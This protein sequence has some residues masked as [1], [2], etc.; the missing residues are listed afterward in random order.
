MSY[1]QLESFIFEKITETKLPGMSAALIKDGEVVW[2]KGFG[3]RDAE[4]GL[5]AT[6]QSL[7]SVGSVTK[8]FT[9]L[10]IMQLAEQGKLKVDDPIDK[11]LPFDIQPGGEKVRI[12]HLMSH[13]SGFP[14]L[15]YAENSISA[16]IGAEAS[17]LPIADADDMIAFMHG[18]ENWTV[19]KPGERWFYLNEGYVLLGG[20]IEKVSGQPYEDYVRANILKPLGMDR[21]VFRQVDVEADPDV[22][23]PYV[24]WADQGRV[25]SKY[26]YNGLAAPGGLLSNVL[27]LVQYISM[28]M[29]NGELNGKRMLAANGIAEMVK[30]RVNTPVKNSPFGQPGY[31]YGW[32]ITPNF[33]GHTLIGHGGSIGVCTAYVGFIPDKKVGVAVLTNGSGYGPGQIGQYGLATL[34]GED[35]EKLPYIRRQRL[36]AGLAGTYETYK[37]TMKWQVKRA[38]DFIMVVD[39]DKYSTSSFPLI[40]E[41]LEDDRRLFYTLDSGSRIDAEFKVKGDQVELIYERYLLR[42][43]GK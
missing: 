3:F 19:T 36:I 40:P 26:P 18:A 15:A 25:P 11:Y 12:W 17:W 41:T 21:S 14:A 10:A 29:G 5:A 34:L 20:I 16:A 6:P 38:G 32:G 39:Q 33:L 22:A 4:K 43:T 9:T 13:S 35:P 8:S 37:G 2:S 24:N 31:G 27:E 7:Y 28:Y 23:T 42:R 1:A 30:P